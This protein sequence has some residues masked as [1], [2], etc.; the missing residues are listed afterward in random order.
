MYQTFNEGASPPYDFT[1]D[2]DAIVK[3]GM[4]RYLEACAARYGEAFDVARRVEFAK[5]YRDTLWRTFSGAQMEAEIREEGDDWH[6]E[7][8]AEIAAR[9]EADAIYAELGGDEAESPPCDPVPPDDP[10]MAAAAEIAE[11]QISDDAWAAHSKSALRS[12]GQLLKEMR[13]RG[14]EDNAELVSKWILKQAR[15]DRRRAESE[16]RQ[17]ERAKQRQEEA[18][19]GQQSRAEEPDQLAGIKFDEGGTASPEPMLIRRLL[20]Q[21][22]IGMC[23]GQSGVGKSFIM[24]HAA[25]ELA[26]G[27]NFFGYPVYERVGSAILAAEGAG[28]MQNR[29]TVARQKATEAAKLPIAWIGN[30]PNLSLEGEVRKLAGRLEKINDHF[31][32]E[33]G[34]RLGVIWIDTL[35]AAA[36]FKEENDNSEVER[37][38]D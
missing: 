25:V 24:C 30:V 16:A 20:P 15:H 28:T 18:S 32:K 35:A 7:G 37:V 6:A 29:I 31:L 36:R 14:V 38:A 33:F 2:F 1:K 12:A 22:G 10:V 3:P 34:V 8:A 17:K 21:S 23:G 27:G 19:N 11:A 26:V 4:L 9:F 5:G 13:H